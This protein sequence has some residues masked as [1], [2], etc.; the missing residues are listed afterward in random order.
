MRPIW[1]LAAGHGLVATTHTYDTAVFWPSHDVEE[2][3]EP[4]GTAMK[5]EAGATQSSDGA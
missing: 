1:A 3:S 5:P 2:H 4:V